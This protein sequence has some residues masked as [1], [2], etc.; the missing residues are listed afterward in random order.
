MITDREIEEGLNEA[1]KKSGQNAYFGNGFKFGAEFVLNKVNLNVDNNF[2]LLF[3]KLEKA[4]KEDSVN[5]CPK[6]NNITDVVPNP[7][8]YWKCENCGHECD[9]LTLPF[10][11]NKDFVRDILSEHY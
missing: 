6:C 1:Y 2:D 5:L 9:Y 4:F 11:N 7:Y 10:K 8:Y 3:K